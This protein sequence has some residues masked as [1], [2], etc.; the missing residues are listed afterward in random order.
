MTSCCM[1]T[2]P[3]VYTIVYDLWRY[4]LCYFGVVSVA[5]I[6]LYF[7]TCGSRIANTY[8]SLH[9]GHVLP[10]M[11]S[12]VYYFM[13]QAT[14]VI[15]NHGLSKTNPC[16]N[17]SIIAIRDSNVLI[18]TRWMW[19][20]VRNLTLMR[21]LPW[22]AH[23]GGPLKRTPVMQLRALHCKQLPGKVVGQMGSARGWPSVTPK[24]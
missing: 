21:M 15:F 4:Y 18:W 13:L 5:L 6:L 19:K 20:C 16:T 17:L 3:S 1:S 22:V 7:S 9:W 12:L 24:C 10:T 11:F 2:L 8:A 23:W 14:I